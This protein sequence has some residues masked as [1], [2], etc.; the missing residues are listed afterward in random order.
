LC[1]GISPKRDVLLA[2]GVD[3][4]TAVG[5][6]VVGPMVSIALCMLGG[7]D[8]RTLFLVA[9]AWG[10]PASTAGERRTGQV[11]TAAAPAPGA[12]WP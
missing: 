1:S 11:L 12:G 6:L 5:A 10:D 8:K 4:A 9:A 7:I 2:G 3:V